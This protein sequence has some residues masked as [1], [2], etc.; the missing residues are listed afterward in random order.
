MN[1]LRFVLPM[2]FVFAI[3]LAISSPVFAQPP[4]CTI[5]VEPETTVVTVGDEFDV[6]IWIRD[7]DENNPIDMFE[8][9]IAWDITEL[10]LGPIFTHNLDGWTLDGISENQGLNPDIHFIII[11]AHTDNVDAAIDSDISM[12]TLRF[13]CRVGGEANIEAPTAIQDEYD[14]TNNP[15]VVSDYADTFL[16][17]DV[18]GSYAIVEQSSPVGGIYSPTDKLSILTPYIAL[19]GLIGAIST[20]FAIRRWRK[21]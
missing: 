13:R 15:V 11:A 7:P 6:K 5:S 3:I 21:D 4:T 16:Q 9:I 2:V 1:K 8:I 18:T 19:V 10:D 20:I 14:Q 17:Y 12:A